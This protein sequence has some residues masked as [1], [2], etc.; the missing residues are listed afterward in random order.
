VFESGGGGLVPTTE[1][2]GDQRLPMGNDFP[3]I[4]YQAIDD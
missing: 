4:V 1:D 3:T 2:S